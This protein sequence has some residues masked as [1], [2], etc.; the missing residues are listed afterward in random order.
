METGQSYGGRRRE[1]E[2][3][4]IDIVPLIDV[5]FLLLFFFVIMSIQM[6]VQKGMPVNLAQV[7]QTNSIQK[8]KTPVVTVQSNQ[9]VYLNKNQVSLEE[10]E[11]QLTKWKGKSD[12]DQLLLNVDRDVRQGTVVDVTDAVRSADIENIVFTVEPAS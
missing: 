2:T 7:E 9:N 3:T 5:I 8:Q 10:L 11:Q 12:R 4:K 6:I 1:A